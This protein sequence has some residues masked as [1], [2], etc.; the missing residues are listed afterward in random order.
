M[1]NTT[2]IPDHKDID[3]VNYHNPVDWWEETEIKHN[4]EL[5]MEDIKFEESR[6]EL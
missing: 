3:R 6:D 2:Y 1:L 5:E 4:A